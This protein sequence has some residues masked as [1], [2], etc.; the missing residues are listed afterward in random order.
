MEIEC[1]TKNLTSLKL[2]NNWRGTTEQFLLHFQEQFRLL[3]DLVNPTEKIGPRFRRILLE[4]AVQDM[5][6]LK[7]IT[8]TDEYHRVVSNSK[9]TNYE[10]YFNLLL[11]AAQKYDHNSRHN[12]HKTKTTIFVHDTGNGEYFDT[13]EGTPY[14][15]ID[16]TAEELYQIHSTTLDECPDV[17]D[18]FYSIFQTEKGGRQRPNKGFPRRNNPPDN[19][20]VR[21]PKELWNVISD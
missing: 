16:L 13:K 1:L 9:S 11:V 15:G 4:A 8:N 5:P 21:L 18:K 3:D 2:D 6:V 19:G 20:Y 7:N 12:P 14:G 10:Q 17:S